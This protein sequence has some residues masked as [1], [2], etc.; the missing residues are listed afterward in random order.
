[1]KV[2]FAKLFQGLSEAGLLN[3]TPADMSKEQI[4]LFCQIARFCTTLEGP[5]DVPF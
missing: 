5:Q 2:E 1:M 3:I 4:E